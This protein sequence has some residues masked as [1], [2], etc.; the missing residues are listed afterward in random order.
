LLDLVLAVRV[1]LRGHAAAGVNT[2]S[3]TGCPVI[4]ISRPPT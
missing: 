4:S 2:I 3:L 1:D